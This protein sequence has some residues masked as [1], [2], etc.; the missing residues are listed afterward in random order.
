[1]RAAPPGAA[2]PRAAPQMPQLNIREFDRTADQLEDLAE[3]AVR[4]AEQWRRF[5]AVVNGLPPGAADRVQS[6]MHEA[7]TDFN[8]SGA[9][10]PVAHGDLAD[11][12]LDAAV[13]AMKDM[14]EGA[15]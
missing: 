11:A 10:G 15:G 13:N 14:L 12:M 3:F 5:V 8:N 2:P 7:A 9:Q 4:P 6:A 1:M